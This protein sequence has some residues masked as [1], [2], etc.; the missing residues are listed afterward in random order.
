M[1]IQRQSK[2]R[3][4]IFAEL[5]SRKD[6]P[7]ADELYQ[8]L[9]KDNPQLSLATVYRNLKQL[10]EEGKVLCITS[11]TSDRYDATVSTHYHFSCDGCH[12]V[13]DLDIPEIDAITEATENTS[14]KVDS[15]SLIYSGL[16]EKC[17]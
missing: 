7:T 14:F 12:K 8:S 11:G 1:P 15:Y 3:N 10:C 5:M 9:K 6:H 17:Q 13:Y 16:C 4:A 2:Q